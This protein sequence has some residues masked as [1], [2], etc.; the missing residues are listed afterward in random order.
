MD[1]EDRNHMH[2]YLDVDAMQPGLE[3]GENPYDRKAAQ[4]WPDANNKVWEWRGRRR[5][6]ME[7]EIWGIIR[8]N[9]VCIMRVRAGIIT[10]ARVAI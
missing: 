3:V 9:R 7:V 6:R 10:R 5:I 4:E 2:K 1:Y 8:V